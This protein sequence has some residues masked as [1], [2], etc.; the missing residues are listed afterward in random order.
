MVPVCPGVSWFYCQSLASQESFVLGNAG[1]LV[2][3]AK[4]PTRAQSV[5][6][7]PCHRAMFH[8]GVDNLDFHWQD[9]KAQT[10]QGFIL[11]LL[12]SKG[13]AGQALGCMCKTAKAPQ[14]APPLAEC[15]QAAPC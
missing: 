4:S 13:G 12:F 3:R 10:G 8:V 14:P 7:F 1:W 2:T 11:G 6:M 15:E 9:T 5:F